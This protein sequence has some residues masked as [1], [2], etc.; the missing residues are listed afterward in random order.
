MVKL[1]KNILYR[2]TIGEDIANAV[3]HGVG[4]VLAYVGLI[5][6]VYTSA[7]NGTTKDVISFS[8]YGTSL[9]FMFLMST[10]Y[11][12]IFHDMT[13]SIFKRL[14]HSAIFIL[15]AGTYVPFTFTVIDTTL[16]YIILGILIIIAISGIVLKTFFVGR[17]KVLSTLTYIVMGWLIIF[18]IKPL[19][20]NLNQNALTFL[21]A[22][23]VIYTIGA[24]IYAFSKFK[25]HHFIWHIFVFIAALCHYIVIAFYIL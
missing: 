6:L 5:Y 10:L 25:Y 24:I 8:I 3:S 18:E 21:V 13:R 23:G 16:S 22:G 9:I 20:A 14:D 4:A 15:I 2:Y 7:V 12:A 19:I 11:H 17:F 1:A